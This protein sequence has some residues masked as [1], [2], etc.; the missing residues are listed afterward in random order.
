MKLLIVDDEQEALD[1]MQGF[2]EAQGVK[3]MTAQGGHEAMAL[4]RECQPKLIMLDIKMRGMDGR[5]ILRR[6]KAHDPGVAVIM[7][8]GLSEDGL[9]EE[10]LALG[11]SH[12]LHKPVRIDQLQEIVQT[13]HG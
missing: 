11:A 1:G 4:V 8:T 3:V 6:A 7:V 12:V 5:E 2:F 13:L 9:E 10:C